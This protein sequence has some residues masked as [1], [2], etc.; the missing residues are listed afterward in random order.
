MPNYCHYSMMIQGR[1]RAVGDVI[2]AVKADYNYIENTFSYKKHLFR[3]FDADIAQTHQKDGIRTAIINGECAWS[4]YSCMLAG[5]H[6]YYDDLKKRFPDEFRG[7]TIF[8]LSRDHNVIIEV[9]GEEPGEGFQEHYLIKFGT[10]MVDETTK[11]CEITDDE[12]AEKNVTIE[13]YLDQF[14]DYFGITYTM[15][16]VEKDGDFYRIGGFDWH[17]ASFDKEE[18]KAKPKAKKK[19]AGDENK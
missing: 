13:E 14:N 15:K 6:T 7:T 1:S 17:F 16:D 10:M 5:P 4:V 18:F 3:V 12:L 2:K 9:F 11:Y 8:E 19:A